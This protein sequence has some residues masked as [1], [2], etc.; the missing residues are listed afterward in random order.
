[1]YIDPFKILGQ[2]LFDG[3]QRQRGLE[4]I[5]RFLAISFTEDY[6]LQGTVTVYNFMKDSIEDVFKIGQIL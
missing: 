1:M 5:M 6:L 2:E 4:D 3:C